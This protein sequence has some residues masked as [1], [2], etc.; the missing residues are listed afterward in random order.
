MYM[1]M[2]AYMYVYICMCI[3]THKCW[4]APWPMLE[5]PGALCSFKKPCSLN[6][7]SKSTPCS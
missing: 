5:P 6:C 7:C 2:Y 3:Y 4:E 1:Y